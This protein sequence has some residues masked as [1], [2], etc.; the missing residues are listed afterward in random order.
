MF[1]SQDVKSMFLILSAELTKLT[2]CTVW[3]YFFCL[4]SAPTEIRTPTL[5]VDDNFITLQWNKPLSTGG[6][7]ILYRVDCGDTGKVVQGNILQAIISIDDL[8]DSVSDT[9]VVCKVRDLF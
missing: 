1:V 8:G 4:F 2:F 7:Q 5:S 6:P 3:A 9:D